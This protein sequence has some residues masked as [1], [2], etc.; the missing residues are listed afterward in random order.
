M[1]DDWE[2]NILNKTIKS[3]YNYYDSGYIQ[4]KSFDHFIHFRLNKIVEEESKLEVPINSSEKY[5]VE[6]G[7]VFVDNPYIID[8]NRNLK[9]ITP[10]EARVREIN[11]S[12]NVSI[13]IKTSDAVALPLFTIKLACF[14][15]IFASFD[16]KFFKPHCSIS[17]AAENP[18]G[19]LKTDP[20]EG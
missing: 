3:F 8:E 6:F 14:S 17:S 13:N 7:Q 5:V 19:F 2:E 10:H 12:G 9:Y 18:L 15:D 11:Y 4:K 1:V 16:E 20:A